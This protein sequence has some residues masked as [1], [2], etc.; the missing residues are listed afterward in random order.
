M[1]LITRQA[2][3][4]VECGGCLEMCLNCWALWCVVVIPS[5][6][7]DVV[8]SVRKW[9]EFHSIQFYLLLYSEPHIDS[10]VTHSRC[11]WTCRFIEDTN[12]FLC[13]KCLCSFVF[14]PIK[15]MGTRGLYL[16]PAG[17]FMISQNKCFY[18][19]SL[20]EQ[21]FV[22][23]LQLI[24]KLLCFSIELLRPLRC[25]IQYTESPYFQA[26]NKERSLCYF[27]VISVS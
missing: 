21:L 19:H 12:P 26:P 3:V 9:A 4:E 5:V 15:N 1:T 10:S 13:L 14:I 20:F 8:P 2:K 6:L 11:H 7:D 24:L 18:L 16:H 23:Y 17:H 22:N 27:N 25:S